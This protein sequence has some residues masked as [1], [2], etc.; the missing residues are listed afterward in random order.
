M[1]DESQY[2]TTRK[3]YLNSDIGKLVPIYGLNFLQLSQLLTATIVKV[4][5]G[6]QVFTTPRERNFWGNY[7]TP[8]R[9]DVNKVTVTLQDGE[10]MVVTEVTG[11]SAKQ[12]VY[13]CTAETVET[14]K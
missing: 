7:K 8:L 2:A 6:E 12:Y 5:T 13:V 3:K 10:F 1:I 14:A 4:T 9:V 11:D